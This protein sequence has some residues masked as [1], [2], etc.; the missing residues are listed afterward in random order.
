MADVEA[1]RERDARRPEWQEPV[2]ADG[3]QW[4]ADPLLGPQLRRQLTHRRQRCHWPAARQS[5]RLLPVTDQL[6]NC[7][8]Q[9]T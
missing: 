6:A 1:L 3:R 7:K 9:N 2:R 4:H 5:N 8:A